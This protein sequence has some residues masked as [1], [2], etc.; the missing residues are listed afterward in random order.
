[1]DGVHTFVSSM[2]CTGI[3]FPKEV[4]EVQDRYQI[5]NS[6]KHEWWHDQE[7]GNSIRNI[8]GNK[9]N[10]IVHSVPK[11][12]RLTSVI[13]GALRLLLGDGEEESLCSEN[14]RWWLVLI[15]CSSVL[16][17]WDAACQAGSPSVVSLKKCS[18]LHYLPAS[19][20][21]SKADH[22]SMISHVL[23]WFHK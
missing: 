15:S 5:L 14:T 13:P 23:V 11:V 7:R 2:N 1:M 22:E 10:P 19:L 20:F 16:S 18:V 21:L 3:N 12:S 17:T 8:K 4:R 6:L 9:G